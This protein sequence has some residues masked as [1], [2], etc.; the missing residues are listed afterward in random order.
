MNSQTS[1]ETNEM[2][3]C[4]KTAAESVENISGMKRNQ[5]IKND[6]PAIFLR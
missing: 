6:V 1:K 3:D 2:P 5:N 4:T